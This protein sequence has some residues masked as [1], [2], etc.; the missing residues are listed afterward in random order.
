[1]KSRFR[2]MLLKTISEKLDAVASLRGVKPPAGGWLR[3]IRLALGMPLHYPARK[4]NMTT[5]GLVKL[6]KAEGSGAI[7]LKTLERAADALNC[8]LVYALLPRDGTLLDRIRGR[9][10]RK[11]RKMIE[12]VGHSML[13]EAQ[14]AE[15]L[16]ERID[17]LADEIA[18]S[19][20]PK[21]WTEE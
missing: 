18:A 17:Q 15:N 6:E 11:A 3:S 10:R 12:P 21:L 14:S 7:S 9:A 2:Q 1:M 8:D 4:L 19:P 13:L 16:D 5:P 20:H